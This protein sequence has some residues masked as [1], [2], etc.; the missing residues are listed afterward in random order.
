MEVTE[1]MTLRESNHFLTNLIKEDKPFTVLRLGGI[2]AYSFKR[3]V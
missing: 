3:Y 1:T 2:E